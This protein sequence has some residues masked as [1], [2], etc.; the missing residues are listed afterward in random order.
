MHNATRPGANGN[1]YP[2]RWICQLQNSQRIHLWRDR[3][4]PLARR[5]ASHARLD[6]SRLLRRE[7]LRGA[8]DM[9]MPIEGKSF[10]RLDLGAESPKFLFT[11]CSFFFFFL[12]KAQIPRCCAQEFLKTNGISMIRRIG[13]T[14]ILEV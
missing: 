10:L 3:G 9:L 12:S 2:G 13:S 4:L 14:V 8:L 11:S 5:R 6:A 1:R 7:S